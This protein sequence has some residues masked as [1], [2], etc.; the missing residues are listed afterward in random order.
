MLFRPGF[1]VLA[2][3][4]RVTGSRDAAVK[5]STDTLDIAGGA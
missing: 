5:G 1:S 3:E 2:G 4:G